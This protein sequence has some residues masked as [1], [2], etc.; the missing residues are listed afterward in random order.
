MSVLPSQVM[1]LLGDVEDLGL[2]RKP[3]VVSRWQVKWK[4]VVRKAGSLLA[5]MTSSMYC[6]CQRAPVNC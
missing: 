3:A 5:R 2:M 4:T 1:Q 6:W